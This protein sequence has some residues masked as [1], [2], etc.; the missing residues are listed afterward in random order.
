MNTEVTR[1]KLNI[2]AIHDAKEAKVQVGIRGEV[3]KPQILLRSEPA[4]S[5]FEIMALLIAGPRS[6]NE[7]GA[8][9]SSMQGE[10]TS[11]V[12]SALTGFVSDRLQGFLSTRTPLTVNLEMQ[13]AAEGRGTV[14]VGQ[15]VNPDLFVSY[16]RQFGAE[17]GENTNE[18]RF[19]YTL[20]RRWSLEGFFGDA[21][22]GGL[23]LFWRM[24][25]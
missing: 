13:D 18:I 9:Q 10:A 8:G 25:F 6:P 4:R 12:S 7:G 5:D 19:D 3:R 2:D 21:Q 17:I 20:T 14:E 11:L 15:Y 23:D 24:R 1:G 16:D 22:E